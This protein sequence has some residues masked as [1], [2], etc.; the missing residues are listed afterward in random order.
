MPGTHTR[1][2]R[3]Q[4][5]ANLSYAKAI[6]GLTMR[7][8]K[9]QNIS[10]RYNFSQFSPQLQNIFNIRNRTINDL[11]TCQ[12]LS[13]GPDTKRCTYLILVRVIN[14]TLHKLPFQRQLRN[15]TRSR[16]SRNDTDV[17]C[18]EKARDGY[19]LVFCRYTGGETNEC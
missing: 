15:S 3:L 6:C 5:L 7:I 11:L 19:G 18:E 4:Q 1:E 9:T 16:K 8:L 10:V 17:S 12:N 14:Q 13:L 2:R